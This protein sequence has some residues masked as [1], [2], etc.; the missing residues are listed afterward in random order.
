MHEKEKKLFEE[1][2]KQKFGSLKTN[3]TVNTYAA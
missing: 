2:K 1:R 3:P